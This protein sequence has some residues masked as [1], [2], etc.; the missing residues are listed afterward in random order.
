MNHCALLIVPS[1]LM[2]HWLNRHSFPFLVILIH[3]GI[4]AVIFQLAL[5]ASLPAPSTTVSGWSWPPPGAPGLGGAALR[6]RLRLV[7]AWSC[8]L[9]LM[10]IYW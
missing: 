7:G 1:G 9:T 2:L 3:H 6:A 4:F 10:S 8:F 5:Q